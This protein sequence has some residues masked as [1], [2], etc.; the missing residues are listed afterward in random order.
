MPLNMPLR[1]IDWLDLGL[2]LKLQAIPEHQIKHTL[3]WVPSIPI[4]QVPGRQFL[5]WLCPLGE[6]MKKSYKAW[7]L[8]LK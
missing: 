4:L 6:M 8:E 1:L 5:Y 7:M 2:F 3:K